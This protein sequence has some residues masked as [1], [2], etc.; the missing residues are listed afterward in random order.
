MSLVRS[1]SSLEEH[2]AKFLTICIDLGGSI[3]KVGRILRDDW[4]KLG[5]KL[6]MD[7]H[8]V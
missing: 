2:C 6:D 4:I 1:R 8:F 5:M 7:L 3:E